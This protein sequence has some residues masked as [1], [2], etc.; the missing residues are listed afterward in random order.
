MKKFLF[1]LLCLTT[2][3]SFSQNSCSFDSTNAFQQCINGG[4]QTII[5]YEWWNDTANC[6][7]DVVSVEYSNEAGFGPFTYPYN[8]PS[9]QPYS[10]F[11][12]FA[13]T[14]NMPPNWSVE[15]YLVINYS[16]GSQSDTITYIPYSCIT[17]CTD[18]NSISYNP[19]ATSD[20][21]SCVNTGVSAC[22]PGEFEVTIEVTLDSYPSETSWLF[23]DQSNGNL[24]F[25]IPQG[26]YTFND[27]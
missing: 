4:S 17:G 24:L 7:L 21:G 27:I 22:P 18:P 14:P 26:T 16:N 8:N 25:N 23:V 3:F 9:S 20:D 5:I 12:V 2:F 11:G 19:W 10:S 13:G 1:L 6:N 15:H